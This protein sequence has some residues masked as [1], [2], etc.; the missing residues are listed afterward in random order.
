M[1][2][3]NIMIRGFLVIDRT[4]QPIYTKVYTEL[5]GLALD[6][7][8]NMILQT[9]GTLRPAQVE[10]TQLIRYRLSYTIAHRHMFL[11][12]SD[13]V[14]AEEE[15]EKIIT[16]FMLEFNNMFQST[17]SAEDPDYSVLDDF[18]DMAEELVGAL[19]VKL[20]LAGFGGVGKTTMRKLLRREDIPLEYRPTM[21]GD[22][23]P[24]AI[25]ALHPYNI[26]LFDFAGQERF[27]VAWDILI[28]GSEFVFIVVDSTPAGVDRTKEKVLPIVRGKAPYAQFYVIANKQDM[29]NA[30]TPEEIESSLGIITFPLVAIDE[31]SRD[32]LTEILY[33]AIFKQPHLTLLEG[34]E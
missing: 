31:K 15:I 10:H 28:Q 21:F 3:G 17:L 20:A 26:T 4:G 9:A 25:G 33:D 11:L 6:S 18:D 23:K 12:I 29:E 2:R 16:R 13:R 5:K 30:M 8:L 7:A 24:V 34:T 14:N 19:P 22:T 32:Q 27:M 1:Q